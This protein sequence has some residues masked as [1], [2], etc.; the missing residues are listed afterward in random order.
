MTHEE[1]YALVEIATNQPWFASKRLKEY[2]ATV[3]VEEGAENAAEEQTEANKGTRTGQQN[4]AI[5]LDCKLI[6]EKLEAAGIDWKSVIREGGIDV[7]VT[8]NAVK[9]FMWKPVM[10][11]LYGYD[12]TTELKKGEGQIEA[13]HETIMRALME[14][15][16]VEWHDFPS[17]DA[18]FW[19]EQGGYK[20]AAGQGAKSVAYPEDTGPVTF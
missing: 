18:R 13:I 14:K 11:L 2:L 19:E 9:E 16:G 12:S 7:P 10:R 15:H 3:Q 8:G 4:R 20:V 6:A 5:H 1:H 17:D